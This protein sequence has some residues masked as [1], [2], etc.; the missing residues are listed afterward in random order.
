MDS[1]PICIRLY[2]KLFSR[3]RFHFIVYDDI[4]ARPQQVLQ[5]L[6][7]FL[8]IDKGFRPPSLH[9]KVN[10]RKAPKSALLHKLIIAGPVLAGS[11]TA[12]MRIKALL[13][14]VG[15]HRVYGWMLEKNLKGT[16][17][18]PLRE[19]TRKRLVRAYREENRL[20]GE[21]L[22]RDLSRWSL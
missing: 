2:L 9:E 20:L 7:L 3:D 21:F 6:F 15:L 18:P 11:G 10:I 13:K 19:E 16:T 4:A 1:M 22:K 17:A 8:G 5:A 14:R 12:G